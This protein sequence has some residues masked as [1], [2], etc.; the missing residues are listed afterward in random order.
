VEIFEE[1]EFPKKKYKVF[2]LY[3]GDEEVYKRLGFN[4][5]KLKNLSNIYDVLN[6]DREKKG[7]SLIRLKENN[8]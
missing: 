2:A 3:I 7:L 8:I 5:D 4:L 1:Q 6:N